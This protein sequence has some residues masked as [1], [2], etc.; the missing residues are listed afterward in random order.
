MRTVTPAPRTPGL[1]HVPGVP[2]GSGGLRAP[3]TGT[4][5]A[6]VRESPAEGDA[7]G[8]GRDGVQGSA[9]LGLGTPREVL[10]RIVPDDPLG[11]ARRV[12]RRLRA[13]ALLLDADRV[14]LRAFARVARA[15][16]AWRGRPAVGRWLAQRID[17]AIADVRG[18][19]A[20]SDAPLPAAF[21]VLGAPLG[22]DPAALWSRC[23]AFNRLAPSEREAFFQLVI[24]RR[25]LDRAAR[26]AGGSASAL[27]RRARVAL[28]VFRAT[29]GQGV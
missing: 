3:G 24:E 14:L 28:D 19:S 7:P 27:A 18:E 2:D 9:L 13:D 6:T 16:P 15:A 4:G 29:E 26:E 5:T 22:L 23:E 8:D 10:A 11:L 1:P 12:A 20:R 25:P 21:E 17:E